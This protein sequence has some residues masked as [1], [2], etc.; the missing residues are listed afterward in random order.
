MNAPLLLL[1]AM[2]VV[3]AI[4]GVYR[5][6]VAHREDDFLHIEDPN[7]QLVAN[8]RQTAHAL[9]KV[10]HIGIGLT[11][12]TA[13]YAVALLLIWLYPGVR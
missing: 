12:A 2:I 11:V 6:I 10:D 13:I 3:T 4:V 5:W 7:G 1:I 8:Q 9:N